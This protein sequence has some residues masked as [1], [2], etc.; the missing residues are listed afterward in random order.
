MPPPTTERHAWESAYSRTWEAV[1][2]AAPGGALAETVAS[3]RT[4]LLA[5]HRQ[6]TLQAREGLR[7][8]LLRHVVVVLDLSRSMLDAGGTAWRPNKGSAAARA[9]LQF[10]ATFLDANPISQLGV[11]SVYDRV[12]HA[13]C[14][15][16][17]ALRDVDAALRRAAA[18]SGDWSLQNGLEA[19]AK[20]LAAA[21]EHGS[22]E[23]IVVTGSLSSND[24]G[25]VHETIAGLAACPYPALC[26]LPLLCSSHLLFSYFFH[27]EFSSLFSSLSLSLS[28]SRPS[29]PPSGPAML[30]RLHK[31]RGVC[32][33]APGE[34]DRRFHWRADA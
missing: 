18:A 9:V 7:R 4:A 11:V 13:L 29:P 10:A 22:R 32:A 34:A 1:G 3:R 27:S 30:D 33:A 12:A 28:L 2:E 19:A 20:V 25:D 6:R 8:G 15:L 23:I 14:P 31:R 24:P 16:T 26:G 17:A 21:P 5:A